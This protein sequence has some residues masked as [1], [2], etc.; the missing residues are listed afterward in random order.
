MYQTS[1]LKILFTLLCNPGLENTDYRKIATMADVALGSVGW[2]MRD[3]K[4]AGYLVDMGKSERTLTRK[5]EL[6]KNW[7]SNYH[8]QLQPKLQLGRYAA[9]DN[10]WWKNFLMPENTLWGSEYAAKEMTNYLKPENYTLYTDELRP[11]F[12]LKNKLHR[13]AEGTIEI[14]QKFW[15]FDGN[16]T[17]QNIVPPLLVYA[18]LIASQSGRNIETAKMIYEKEIRE[19][20]R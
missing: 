3:L 15:A 2:V 20:I 14:L 13:S 1:G 19:L 16:W 7:V 9:L 10:N 6:L 12:L 4:L 17:K 18:D 11:E 8:D 5:E